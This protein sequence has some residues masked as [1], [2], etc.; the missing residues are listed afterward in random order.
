MEQKIKQDKSVS[1][2]FGANLAQLLG[3]KI[4]STYPEFDTQNIFKLLNPNVM[5]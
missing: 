2:W 3:E 5:V 4:E 1:R